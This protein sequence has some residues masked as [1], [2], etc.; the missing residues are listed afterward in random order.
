MSNSPVTIVRAG[1]G[2]AEALSEVAAAT[3]P[4]ACPP[5][6]TAA[7][8]AAFVSEWLS[9]ERFGEYLTDPTRTVLK[10]VSDGRIVGYS[11]LHTAEPA[12]PDVAA[13]ITLRQVTELSKMY[14]LPGHHGDGVSAGLMSAV[15]ETARNAGNAAVWLG[16]N[17]ENV[18]A[19]RFYSKHGFEIAGT[20]TFLVGTQ[21]HSDYVMQ[22]KF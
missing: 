15:L 19:Q 8:I 14:V 9:P 17:Q 13:V 5:R 4:L 21:T 20:K 18:R 22:Y 11:L 6:S 3:F 10:A 2:D 12:N 7:D 16:V 1:R